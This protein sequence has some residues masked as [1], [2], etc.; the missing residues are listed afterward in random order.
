MNQPIGIFCLDDNEGDLILLEN[1]L[2]EQGIDNY[3][4]YNSIEE[5]YKDF[6]AQN[7]R[8]F[9]LD[10]T[11]P[12][13]NGLEVAEYILAK[14]PYARII[15]HSGKE[16]ANEVIKALNMNIFKWVK[17]G[18]PNHLEI[19]AQYVLNAIKWLRNVKI[20]LPDEIK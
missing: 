8:V 13:Q 12:T 7:I 4:M 17:K 16:D 5:F 19:C 1:A 2:I 9:V 11:L 14:K 20:L 15:I 3:K 6:E 18:Q 10:Y